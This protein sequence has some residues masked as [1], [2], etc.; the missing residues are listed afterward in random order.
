MQNKDTKN[1][2]VIIG[3]GYGG[4]R[5]VERLSANPQNEIVLIDKNPYHFL[6]TDLYDLIANE[7][8]FAQVTIDLFTFCAGFDNCV[9]FY[10]EEVSNIDFKNKKIITKNK[11]HSYDY[12]VIAT[13]S[14]TKFPPSVDG[15]NEYAYGTK[16]LTRAIEFKQ[17]FELSLLHKI[18]EHGAHCTPLSIII[19]GA[20]LSG[21]EIATQMA[22][23]SKNFY[24][25]NHFLCR[26]LNIVLV[27]AGESILT[28]MD[29]KLIKKSQKRL[30]ELGVA[31]ELNSKVAQVCKNSALLSNGKEIMMDFMIFTGGIEP[32]A[33]CSSLSLDKD[34]N[35]FIKINQFM[36]TTT[37]EDVFA[38]GDCATFT[39]SQKLPQTADIAEQMGELCAHNIQSLI[40]K[41]QL[42][43]AAIG[44][45]GILIALGTNYAVAKLSIFYFS[46]IVAYVL[47][48][49]VEKIYLKKL[50]YRA[51][52]G[53]KKIFADTI[54]P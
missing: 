40:D 21:V 31:I 4:L 51:S 11:R 53:C 35:S 15:L 49:I 30:Q 47:K 36:Q 12:L 19:A 6:Q 24:S 18:N 45:R 25:R 34:E 46:G 37:Y 20:G 8:D 54:C 13:G 29:S 42:K 10:N 17:K 41:K 2:I 26:K 7:E 5:V 27:S 33:L 22:S 43:P 44:S 38:I 1:K 16:S 50:S 3:G 14:K 28:G 52:K 9:S 32:S 23:Y 39:T 48:K